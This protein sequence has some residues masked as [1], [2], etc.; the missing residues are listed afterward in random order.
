MPMVFGIRSP[1]GV[2]ILDRN[3]FEEPGWEVPLRWD[4]ELFA[5]ANEGEL[6]EATRVRDAAY[7]RDPRAWW[8]R[9]FHIG[10]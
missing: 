10:D 9:F 6:A 3:P 8:R 2:K 5:Y 1:E 4:E 7:L